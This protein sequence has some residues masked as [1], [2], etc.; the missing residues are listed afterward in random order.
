MVEISF[1]FSN[2]TP[3]LLSKN[4]YLINLWP[5]LVSNGQVR[6][7]LALHLPEF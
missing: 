4:N 5:G 2:D 7:K 6:Q 3:I 1:T